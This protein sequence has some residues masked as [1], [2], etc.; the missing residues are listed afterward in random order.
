MSEG[1]PI[2]VIGGGVAGLA[3]AVELARADHRVILLEARDRLGGRIF[4]SPSEA[5]PLELGAEFIHGGDSGLWKWIHAGGLKTVE[6]PDRHQVLVDGALRTTDLWTELGRLTR[7]IDRNAPD[8]SFRDFLAKSN[9]PESLQRLGT[10]F[11]EGFDAADPGTISAHSLAGS[12]WGQEEDPG[13]QQFRLD[14][15]YSALIDYM[16]AQLNPSAVE[17][18]TNAVIVSLRWEPGRVEAIAEEGARQVTYQAQEAV[19]T[20][21]LG[22]LKSGAVAF[23]PP[24]REKAEAIEHLAFGNVMKMVLRFR[25]PFW[26]KPDFGFIHAFNEPIPTWWSDERGPILTGWAGGPKAD[27]L[28]DSGRDELV[29]TAI[30]V[31]SRL[32]HVSIG[33]IHRELREVQS[34]DWRAD[35]FS[36]GAYSYVP[37]N[38]L[39]LP[40]LLATPIGNT[41]FF[42]GEAA[43]SDAEP[44]TVHGALT[45]GIR[46]AEEVLTSRRS[47][48]VHLSRW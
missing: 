3:A 7:K 34:H 19:M 21:P 2:L 18:K 9:I 12:D 39:D 33:S 13:S 6:V 36:R 4:T 30:K 10:G 48:K 5:I 43:V 23:D 27:A 20:L 8:Q 15:G 22:V 16:A 35:P 25:Q 17:I 1:E 14:R 31:L 29:D 41:L 24:L 11:V 40:K 47:E 44:G 46:A 38:G 26:H 45:S 32:F 42:A 28:E 37:V